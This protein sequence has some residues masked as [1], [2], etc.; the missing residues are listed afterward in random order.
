MFERLDAAVAKYARWHDVYA[1][2][3]IAA[4]V[5]AWFWDVLFAARSFYARDILNYHYPMKKL[6]RDAILAGE[7]PMWSP[8][9][10]AGQPMAA[11]PAYEVFYP[12][13]LLVLLPDIHFGLTL[14]VVVHFYICGIGLY[15]FLRSLGTGSVAATL[16]SVAYTLGGPF[17]SLVRTLPFLFSMAWVPLI[18]L[19]ARRYFLAGSRRDLALAVIC[20]GMQ[21]LVAEPTT[22]LQTWLIVA[23][24]AAYR[25]YRDSSRVRSIA[26]GYFAMGA[27]SA[28]VAAAQL[29][30][31]LD[32]VRDSVRSQPL[33]WNLMI[34]KWSLAPAR[35]LELFYPLVFQS[36]ID[37]NGRQWISTMYN[38]GEPFVSSFY[39]GFA[40]GILFVAGMVA[41]RRGS[42]FVLAVCV[43]LYILAIGSNTPVLRFLYDIGLFSTMRYSEK[44]AMSAI[45]VVVVWGAL[46]ADLL[47]RGD[48]RVR[49]A[50]LYVVAGWFVIGMFLTLTA[51]RVWTLFW[52]VTF[53]RGVILL[54]L[55]YAMRRW[56]SSLWPALLVVITLLDVAHLRT[57]NPTIGRDYFDPPPVTKQLSPD[58]DNYRIFHYAEWDWASAVPNADAYFYHPTGR[59]WALRS[60]LMTRNGAWWDHRYALDRDYDQTLLKTSERLT[61]AMLEMYRTSPPGWEEQMMAMSNAW[62]F[63]RFRPA[64]EEITRTNGNWEAIMPVDLFPAKERYPRFYFADQIVPINDVDD[65]VA[66]ILAG[67]SSRRAAFVQ[68]PPFAPAKGTVRSATETLRTMR[69]EAE[70]EGRSLLMISV[71]PHKYWRARVD[72]QAVEPRVVNI[73]YQAI[74]LLA[75]RHVVEMEYWNPLVVPSLVFSLLAFLTAVV[76]AFVSTAAVIPPDEIQPSTLGLRPSES[77]SPRKQKRRKRRG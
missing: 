70:A 60:S 69:I 1:V 44:F 51:A 31:M 41:W 17:L 18:F 67:R 35:V 74:E 71:T 37:F 68:W 59:W 50:V 40:I 20:G 3:A 64:A 6:V 34:T 14:H 72:G 42:A 45:L 49:S 10:A 21:A 53:A 15:Y 19:F 57:I 77:G 5:T 11:N 32:F 61:Y 16:G 7:W 8:Y 43:V 30:P 22:I 73:A 56:R 62:Y 27:G 29:V 65:F 39:P 48:V 58:K 76:L 63:G 24:Y 13:Q 47:F 2:S 66:K 26:A 28:A 23:A 38:L 36:L 75:G 9:F 46:T 55:L 4:A 52:V 33:D 54:L 12:P 25:A